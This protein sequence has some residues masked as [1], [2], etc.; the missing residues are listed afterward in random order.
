MR[1]FKINDMVK[2]WFVGAFEPTI[3]N[4]SEVEVAVKYYKKGDYEERHHHRVA[5]ELTVVVVGSIQMNGQVFV[6]GD[7][8]VVEPFESTDFLAL[9]DSINTVV[10]LPCAQSD[11]FIGD[12]K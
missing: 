7:I 1:V 11:K 12:F 10:K 3:I 5:T 4:T 8:I 6:S 9:E 2:G